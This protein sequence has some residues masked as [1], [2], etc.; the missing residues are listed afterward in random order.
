MAG[1]YEAQSNQPGGMD[2]RTVL[3]AAVATGAASAVWVA[4]RIETLGFAPAG[5]LGTPC[6]ILSPASDDKNSN[7]GEA[8]CST[9][10]GTN[11]FPCCAN[12][13]NFGNNGGPLDTWTFEGPVPGCNELVVALVPLDCEPARGGTPPNP[14][15]PSLARM[16][17][18]ILSKD[19]TCPCTIKEGVLLQ[20]S[21]RIERKTMSHGPM[22]CDYP[23]AV[24]GSGVDIS[25]ACDDPILL[26]VGNDARLAVRITCVSDTGDCVVVP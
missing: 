1:E 18:V 4:P 3:K 17:V 10:G 24:A 12:G 2:R 7:T 20:S 11:N 9:V 19:G 15:D 21:Q 6:D 26:D 14:Q 5:A 16:G 25:L 22:T 13:H 8:Y 23:G